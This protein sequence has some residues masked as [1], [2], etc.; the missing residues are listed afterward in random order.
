MKGHLSTCI[1]WTL[2]LLLCSVA[3]A[4]GEVEFPNTNFHPAVSP[5][6]YYVTEGGATLGHL[7]P[8]AALLLHYAHRPLRLI[9]PANDAYD[10]SLVTYQFNADLLVGLGLFDRLEVGLG[11][12][13][14][15][16]QGTDGL[17]ALGRSPGE[18][19]GAGIG[20]IRFVP[21]V[22][23]L[24]K[25]RITLAMAAPLSF[26]SGSKSN[27]LGDASVT[28][29]PTVVGSYD[30]E[31]VSVALNFGYRFRK[32]QS[33]TAPG[34][35]QT[36]SID[37]EVL[38]SVGG[39][40]GLW[41]KLELIA[42]LF[43]AFSAK[44]LDKEEVQGELLPGLRYHLPM[45]LVANLAVG[46][47]LT[48]GVGTPAFRILAGIAYAHERKEEPKP[49]PKP[50]ED[51]DPDRD[52]ILGA[53]DGCPYDPE[54][55]DDFED[56]DGCPEADNDKDGIL[57][58][59]DKCPNDPEDKD[60]FED[61]DG[62][63]D[64]D[65]DK[66]GILD[67]EDKCP[68]EPEDKDNF[69]DA[70]GCP[71]TDNDK[72]GIVDASDKCPNEPEMFN[73]FEDE[74]GCPDVAKGPVQITRN[75]IVVK[76]VHFATGKDVVLKRSMPI[77]QM[78]AEAITKNPWV[79]KVR[80]E[81]HTDDR[82]KDDYNLDLSRRRAKTVMEHLVQFGVDQSKV[83]SEGYGESNPVADNKSAAGRAKNRR[84][85]FVI[86]DPPQ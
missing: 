30:H 50:A 84:V 46:A 1:G 65:N 39:R 67:A 44:E 40:V 34:D 81:G 25:R 71:D 62:C 12:P 17:E 79:K 61:A 48:Q 8:S 29:A 47:G 70:D 13:V 41:K 83:E 7:A 59:A 19:I 54:D 14:T 52:G 36:V 86:V 82:G 23:I 42:D 35:K 10:H 60:G 64:T 37:D 15:L 31:R 24:T 68:N 75:K 66:D 63:P 28:F 20:D 9:D 27:L 49:P 22:R 80:V 21:K 5:L 33:F 58:S 4:R 57:D 53:D 2:A 38:M 43:W 78:V 73:G 45:N 76:P 18:S 69:E 72:D 26:P 16:A 85:D 32:E 77:L 56:S 3:P 55:K 74:D 6:N 11:L 51:P